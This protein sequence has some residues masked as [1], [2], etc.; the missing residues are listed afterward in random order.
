MSTPP[1]VD[2]MD[3]SPAR[4]KNTVSQGVALGL[5]L[6]GHETIPNNKVQVDLAF[7]GAWRIWPQAKTFITVDNALKKFGG[8]MRAVTHADDHKQSWVFYWERTSAG[9]QIRARQRDWSLDDPDDI[10]YALEMLDGGVTAEQ[11]RELA[12]TFVTRLPR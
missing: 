11:W 3:I 9:Y 4:Q 7:E 2:G 8:G 10:E 12:E 1:I 5:L 6:C